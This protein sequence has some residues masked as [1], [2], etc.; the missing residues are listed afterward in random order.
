MTFPSEVARQE[1]ERRALS[2]PE[3]ARTFLIKDQVQLTAAN[4]FLLGIKAL[5]KEINETFDPIIKAT[6][7]AHR[8]AL[9]KKKKFEDPLVQAE[10]IVKPMIATYLD[11][12]ERIRRQKEA[13]A[14]L[15]EEKKRRLE[16][17]ALRRAMRAEMR[18]DSEKAAQILAKAEEKK[19]ALAVDVPEKAQTSGLSMREIWRY[20]VVDESLLPREFM[21]KDLIKIGKE[22]QVKRGETNIPGVRVWPEKIVAA[23]IA[24]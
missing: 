15:A 23:R 3:R 13:E 20:E 14:V 22:V 24:P 21:T 2:L 7:D 12:Q 8:E 18:G 1:L 9:A 16:E 4:D 11:E 17:E 5:Q 6:N 10:R 19:E